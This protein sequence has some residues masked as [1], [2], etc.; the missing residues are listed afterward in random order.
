MLPNRNSAASYESA[1]LCVWSGTLKEENHHMNTKAVTSSPD[2]FSPASQSST[3]S[4]AVKCPRTRKSSSI[5]SSTTIQSQ[6]T[7]ANILPATLNFF[8]GER[9][10]STTRL[11]ADWWK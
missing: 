4:V 10:G 5:S 6:K 7:A 8:L 11:I 9:G 2:G 3:V 1:V